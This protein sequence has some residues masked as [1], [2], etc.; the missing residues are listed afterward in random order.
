M[1]TKKPPGCVN[2]IALGDF[3]Q[4]AQE[5]DLYIFKDDD[6]DYGLHAINMRTYHLYSHGL[7]LCDRRTKTICGL[8]N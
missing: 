6:K 7:K 8:L 5:K 3:Y 4:M 2:V 1:G